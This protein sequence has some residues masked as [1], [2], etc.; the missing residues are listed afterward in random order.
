MYNVTPR[1]SLLRRSVKVERVA[2][3]DAV[4][5]LLLLYMQ[6]FCANVPRGYCEWNIIYVTYSGCS[7]LFVFV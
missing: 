6:I 3:K 5:G 2:G 4:S 1:P 7:R